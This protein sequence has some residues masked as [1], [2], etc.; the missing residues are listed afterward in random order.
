MKRTVPAKM[1]LARAITAVIRQIPRGRV[2]T[3]GA[4][5]NAAGY[6]SCARHVAQV[7]KRVPGLPW[8]RVVGSGGRVALPGELGMEQRF[9]L[10]T[11]KVP[12]KGRRV[13]LVASEYQFSGASGRKS[14]PHSVV[15]RKSGKGLNRFV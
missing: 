9:L 10:Q 14:S 12:F 4:I 8:H 2:S 15:S 7:L 6:P 11:E 13:D 3:Y 5:A 1:P